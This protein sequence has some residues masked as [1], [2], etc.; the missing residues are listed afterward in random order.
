[1]SIAKFDDLCREAKKAI[2]LRDW[3][4]ARAS[5]VEALTMRPDEAD[6][7][8]GLATV[9]FQ[10]KDIRSAAEHFREVTRLDPLRAG[11]FVN[12]GAIL[13]ILGEL[14]EAVE[15]LRRGIQLDPRRAEGFYN[16]GLVYRQRKQNDLAIEA[17]REAIRVNPKM[18]DAYYNL[19]NIFLDRQDYQKAIRYYRDALEARPGWSKVEQV[20]GLAEQAQAQQERGDQVTALND[21]MDDPVEEPKQKYQIDP[22]KMLDPEEHRELL[23]SI[24]YSTQKAQEQGEKYQSLL[25]QSLEPALKQL[26][27]ALLSGGRASNL[28][29]TLEQF[30][31]ALNELRATHT[32]LHDLLFKIQSQGAKFAE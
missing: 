3:E 2:A 31:S 27:S 18:A 7:H 30:E 1:M 19:G 20:L 17:Y 22:S 6:V 32:K 24:H 4:Q 15:V 8:Q 10:L 9:C 26:S 11:A 23:E 5:Y 13:N 16:L 12:L 21:T 28:H 25:L 29:S 14:D